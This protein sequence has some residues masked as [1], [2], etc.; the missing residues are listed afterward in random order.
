[1]IRFGVVEIVPL[2]QNILVDVAE[3]RAL[4]AKTFRDLNIRHQ[5]IDFDVGYQRLFRVTCQVLCVTKGGGLF[6]G[7]SFFFL[8]YL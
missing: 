1:V 3:G 6:T 8:V 5:H 4:L 7:G 2:L